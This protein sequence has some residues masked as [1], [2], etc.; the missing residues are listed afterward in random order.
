MVIDERARDN[1]KRPY[2]SIPNSNNVKDGFRDITYR[3]FANAI[4]RCAIWLKDEIGIST[5]FEA[6]VYIG[7]ADLRYQILCM[8]AVKTGHVVSWAMRTMLICADAGTDVLP[9]ASKHHGSFQFA[10]GGSSHF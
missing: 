3:T 10:A 9:F 1:H 7:P 5:S 2:A 4:N 8:A 6:M